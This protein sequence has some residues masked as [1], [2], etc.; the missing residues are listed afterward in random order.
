MGWPD[1]TLREQYDANRRAAD[2]PALSQ[3]TSAN[4]SEI[5]ARQTRRRAVLSQPVGNDLAGRLCASEAETKAKIDRGARKSRRT[6]ELFFT[7]TMR[8]EPCS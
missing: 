5:R 2:G 7:V 3:N 4:E 8:H 1:L 6:P